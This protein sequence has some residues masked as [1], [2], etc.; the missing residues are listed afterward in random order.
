[1]TMISEEIRCLLDKAKV[2]LS[3]KEEIVELVNRDKKFGSDLPVRDYV[4][5][6]RFLTPQSYGC[7]LQDL[8]IKMLGLTPTPSKDNSGDCR[9][10]MGDFYE[11]KCS[12]VT[13]TNSSLNFVQIRPWQEVRG[14]FGIVIDTRVDPYRIE[15][16]RLSKS[17]MER[18]CKELNATSA[19]GTRKANELNSNVEL[20]LSV[21]I[22]QSNHHYI[23]WKNK[24]LSNFKF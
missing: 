23:R 5:I 13:T 7:K 12:I 11:V 19:H 6:L 21:P 8:F 1:M 9:D 18:E 16:Y 15:V 22:D 17:D 2:A 4:T 3:T 24:Y 14:Y 10:N 20:R